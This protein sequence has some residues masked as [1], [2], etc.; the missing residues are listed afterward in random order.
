M[1]LWDDFV[2]T[3]RRSV[4]QVNPW[5]NGRNWNTIDAELKKK[6]EEEE[7][8]QVAEEVQEVKE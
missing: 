6:K 7:A 5:D 2:N 3:I 8:V 1:A 4:D